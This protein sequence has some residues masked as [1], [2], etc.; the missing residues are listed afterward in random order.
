MRDVLLVIFLFVAIYY[1]FKR[2]YLGMAAWVWIALTAPANWAFGFSNAFRL[3]LT[4]VVVTALAYLFVQKNKKIRLGGLGILVFLFCFWTLITT[5]FNNNTTPSYVWYVFTEFVK[6]AALF[7][8][9][10]LIIKKRLH[11]DTIVWAIILS[12]SSYAG[13]EAVKYILSAGGHQIIGRA[14]IMID[15]NDLAVAINMC[16][17]LI[18]YLIQTTKHKLL[19]Y[20]LWALLFLNVVAIVGTSSR[21]GFIGLSILAFFF[22]LKSRN[23]IVWALLALMALPVLYHQAPEKWR[24]RQS[25]IQT[26]ATEDGSFIGRLWAWKI[27]SMI[28]RDDPLTGGGFRAVT[29]PVLWGSY[30]PYTPIFGVIETPPIPANKSP[31]AAH[32]IY[33]QVLGDHGYVGLV[34]FLSILFSA[35]RTNV[36]SLKEM[37]KK[38]NIWGEKL[39]SAFYLSLIGYVITGGNVSLAYFDLSFALYG[40]IAAFNINISKF[41]ANIKYSNISDK[42]NLPPSKTNNPL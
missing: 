25:T 20:G 40:L 28:A 38:N 27:S 18:V 39:C 34:L 3:N 23:K 17:P 16:I 30:A 33:F 9:L 36:S 5:I 15:R 13:M 41:G 12:V 10:I 11:I 6:V 22:W 29:D 1:A 31:K 42:N 2:P 4:I 19:R 14:G 7:F 21:G 26:A 37:R 24:E 8:F 32:N 35:Y